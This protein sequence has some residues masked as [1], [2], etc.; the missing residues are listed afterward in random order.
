MDM[1]NMLEKVNNIKVQLTVLEEELKEI[2]V[3]GTD[4]NEMIIAI[5]SGKGMVKDYRFNPGQMSTIDKDSLID[6]VVEATNNALIK[7]KKLEADKKKKIVGNI[8]LPDIPGLF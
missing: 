2:T 4:N 8:N 3:E 5:V 7:A 1:D 6:A